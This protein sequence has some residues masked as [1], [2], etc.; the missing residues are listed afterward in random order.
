MRT[1]VRMSLLLSLALAGIFPASAQA[2]D[3]L[4]FPADTYTE[5]TVTVT[6]SSGDVE[7]GYHLYSNLVYVANPVDADYQSMN[8]KVPVTIN[9]EPID[10]TNAPILFVIPVGGYM[11]ASVT[12][13]SSGGMGGRPMGQPPG[14]PMGGNSSGVS[15]SPDLALAAGYVVVEAGARGRD[16]Q[17]AD[18]TYYGK[19]PAAIV[20]LKAAVRYL[21]HN[22]AI[23]PGNA[24]WIIARGT[25]AGGALASLLGASGDSPL[26]EP[27]LTDLGA[28]DA[29]DAIFA[30][31]A[32][33]P[34]TDLD[35]ADLAYEWAFGSLS[36]NADL[37]QLLSDAYPAYLASLELQGADGFG[38][39]TADNYG[40]YLVQRY[41]APSATAY[42]LT[43][44]DDARASYLDAN[45]WI[46]WTDDQATFSFA[47]YVDHV[48]RKKGT[49]A[50]DALDLS[51]AENSLFGN[52]TT[53]A[54]HFTDVSAAQTGTT[55]DSDVP[56]L[57]TL[58]NPLSFIGQENSTVPAFW[59]L[60]VGSSD[61]DTSP[62]IVS[63]LA[64]SL[65]NQGA[66]VDTAYYWD[67]G[68]GADEDPEAMIA[69]IA[70]I[71][72]YSQ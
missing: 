70:D 55:L 23:M 46:S 3:P 33:C 67:A 29:S 26:Y 58:M 6:T 11:S 25:S 14:G 44:S 71:T 51:S 69:W 20:D 64:L 7:V 24:E 66:E 53:N 32:Y 50:F 62:T 21:H 22:D 45:P 9:G 4:Q 39:I 16:N 37:S 61:T 35:H 27:Y 36:S 28:A 43:L 5:E 18:G 2:E 63:T 41:L 59:W 57:V 34:I 60:R 15:S 10:A 56:S 52:V 19:A 8:V 65:E 72:G 42:L 47:D 31:A 17:A 30:V 49:P 1:L 68:H 54:R 40:D 12:G 48:G 13:A 38:T